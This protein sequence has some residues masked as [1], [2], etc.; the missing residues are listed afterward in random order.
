MEQGETN[1]KHTSLAV[2]LRCAP[3]GAKSCDYVRITKGHT[4]VLKYEITMTA[5]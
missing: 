1:K 2:Q 5:S 4:G 3:G